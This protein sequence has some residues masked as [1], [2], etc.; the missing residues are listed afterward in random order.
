[1][2]LLLIDWGS[3]CLGYMCI[4]LYV[5]L[6]WCSGVACNDVG[7]EEG[8]GQCAIGIC[9]FCS[10][11]NLCGVMVSTDLCSIQGGGGVNL[12]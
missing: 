7:L 9:A 6:I 2:H 4:L 1:M 10:I 11:G 3:I 5:K 12:P 8:V